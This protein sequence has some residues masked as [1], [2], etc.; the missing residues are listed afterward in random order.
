MRE[1]PS[2][3]KVMLYEALNLM[4]QE[5]YERIL[6]HENRSPSRTSEVS[7]EGFP[8]PQSQRMSLIKALYETQIELDKYRPFPLMHLKN[9]GH[10]AG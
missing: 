6:E 5:L 9:G 4:Q 8:L 10:H 2:K 7:S 1:K 3:V